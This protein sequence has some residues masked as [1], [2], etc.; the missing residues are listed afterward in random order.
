M[1]LDKGMYYH[2]A[3]RAGPEIRAKMEKIEL[4]KCFAALQR[5]DLVVDHLRAGHAA[6]FLQWLP[7]FDADSLQEFKSFA[8]IARAAQAACF[9]ALFFK[10]S[11]AP[12]RRYTRTGSPVSELLVR[13]LVLPK[14]ARRELRSIRLFFLFH[15]KLV[16][17][18]DHGPR[19]AVPHAGKRVLHGGH[20]VH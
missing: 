15:N 20:D 19:D 17:G 5:V 12:L 2:D 7:F 4:F 10:E 8:A 14:R 9:T 3:F 1:L 6:P 11:E 16:E 18:A 13:Y